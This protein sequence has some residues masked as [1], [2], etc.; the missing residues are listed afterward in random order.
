M[1]GKKTKPPRDARGDD[2]RFTP[3]L[4]TDGRARG[5]ARRRRALVTLAGDSPGE[6]RMSRATRTVAIASE[7]KH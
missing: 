2:E 4:P 7:G 1:F 5:T 6:S 3:P